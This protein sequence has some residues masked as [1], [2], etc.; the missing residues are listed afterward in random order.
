MP[1]AVEPKKDSKTQKV[2]GLNFEMP[3]KYNRDEGAVT[4]N[5][6]QVLA[7]IQ[8]GNRVEDEH[9]AELRGR[10]LVEIINGVKAVVL[11]GDNKWVLVDTIAVREEVQ[12]ARVRSDML[13]KDLK[14]SEAAIA[15]LRKEHAKTV[16]DLQD[17]VAREKKK[18]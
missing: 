3:V 11:D 6:G 18:R 16:K 2:E 9:V 17:E 12:T 13:E 15:D 8:F 14:K 7:V 1:S 4:D 5:D 10:L